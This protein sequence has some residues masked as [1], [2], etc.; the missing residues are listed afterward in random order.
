ME[1]AVIILNWNAVAA[2]IRCVRAIASWECLYPAIWVVDN[3]SADGSAD[4]IARKCPDVR[5]IRNLANLGFAGGN[6]QGIVQALS[7]GD[8]PILLLNNDAFIAEKDVIRLMDTLQADERLGCVGPLLFDADGTGELLSA[9]GRDIARYTN[10]HIRKVAVGGSVC[11]VDYVPGTVVLVRAEVF[12][13]VG[14][15]DKDYFFSGEVADLCERARQYGYVSAIDT[16][17]RA[18]HALRCSSSL[19][20]RLYIYYNFRNRFLFIRKFRHT[21]R[22]L[23]YGFWTLY[24]LGVSLKAQLCG[25]P[26]KARAI[27][28]GLVDGLQG[29]FGGQNERV[30]SIGSV[31]TSS[32]LS[33][34]P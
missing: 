12:C 33:L 18:F 7:M 6:N 21:R 24:G 25:K 3:D 34:Q 28:L 14:L 13:T 32:P 9:G 22:V 11:K 20:E 5:L 10:T 2:T 26:A 23:L 1:L 8:A 16:R 27:R 17:A 15:F 29:R 30:L 19:R 4:A 31:A